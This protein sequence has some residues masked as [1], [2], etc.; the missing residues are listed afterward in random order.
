MTLLILGCP[1]RKS[2]DQSLI[3]SSPRLIAAFY[4]LHRYSCVKASIM[5]P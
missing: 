5:R 3:D 2:P 4:V 1:I